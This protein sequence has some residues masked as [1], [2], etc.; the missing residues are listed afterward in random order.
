MN[1]EQQNIIAKINESWKDLSIPERFEN[2]KNLNLEGVTFS[3]S[4]SLEDQIITHYIVTKN[5]DVEQFTLDTGR[6]FP[7]IYSVHHETEIK[8]KIKIKTFF[9]NSDAVEDFV[10]TKG[11]NAF[12]ESKEN[13]HACC[14]IRKIEPLKRALQGK[15]FWI[16]GLRAAHS[17]ARQALQFAEWDDGNELIKLNPV[18]DLSNQDMWYITEKEHIPF[19]PMFRQGFPSIGCAPCT[20]AIEPGEPMRA[21]RWWWEQD[22]VQECGLHYENGRL[23]RDKKSSEDETYV[24]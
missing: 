1:T 7:E 24:I 15:Q 22:G 6:M 20:R 2:L 8:Y 3:N 18:M 16:T 10:N 11:I 13:R 12:Y 14:H 5:V 23:V 9:P 21:G 17:Q 19:N 4:F